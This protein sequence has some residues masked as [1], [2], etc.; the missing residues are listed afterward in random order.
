[1]AATETPAD[2]LDSAYQDL[3][4]A[5]RDLIPPEMVAEF[6][7][8]RLGI[9]LL[10]QQFGMELSFGNKMDL[11][12]GEFRH[13]MPTD[14]LGA[15]WRR[16][17]DVAEAVAA[18]HQQ[19]DALRDRPEWKRITA[20]YDSVRQ[21]G[22]AVERHL[23]QY[24]DKVLADPRGK[25][26]LKTVADLATGRIAA[27]AWVLSKALGAAGSG[28]ARARQAVQ[29]LEH[30]AKAGASR[31]EQVARQPAHQRRAAAA[32]LRSTTGGSPRR[33]TPQQKA[34]RAAAPHHT[35]AKAK[36]ATA[37]P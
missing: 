28:L 34:S 25:R 24:K 26:A 9:A 5:A 11:A 32:A 17:R 36:T 23:G 18:V 31:A 10:K 14:Q 3:E 30:V 35:P 6:A 15:V 12:L 33:A 8:I 13:G 2:P 16:R 1:M 29:W 19:A 20:T 4:E 7:E 22:G 37:T 21:F 27:D